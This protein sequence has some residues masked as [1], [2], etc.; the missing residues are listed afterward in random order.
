MIGGITRNKPAQ[1]VASDDMDLENFLAAK[2]K[3]VDALKEDDNIGTVKKLCEII[4]NGKNNRIFVMLYFEERS[5]FQSMASDI[6]GYNCDFKDVIVVPKIPDEY[7]ELS[8]SEVVD[9]LVACK[10]R[11]QASIFDQAKLV[12]SDFICAVLVDDK[13]SRKII[14]YEWEAE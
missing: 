3:V 1:K 14:P 5:R 8:Y 7:E 13:V 6:F 2:T 9:T 10:L 12:Q 11:E 4:E